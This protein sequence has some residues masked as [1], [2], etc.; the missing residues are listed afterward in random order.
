MS[1]NF[2]SIYAWIGSKP[3]KVMFETYSLFDNPL[4]IDNIQIAQ[5][6]DVAEHAESEF[7]LNIYPNPSQGILTLDIRGMVNA[8]EVNIFNIHGKVVK[9]FTANESLDMID[10]SNFSKG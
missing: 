9:S 6:V 10:M 7:T 8:S 3:V 4:Y 5:T 1:F 2:I